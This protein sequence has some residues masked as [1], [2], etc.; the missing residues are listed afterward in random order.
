MQFPWQPTPRWL[1]V[2]AGFAL[3]VGLGVVVVGAEP[4]VEEHPVFDLLD[5]YRS[6]GL[7]LAGRAITHAGDGETLVLATVLLVAAMLWRKKKR[8]ALFVTV[9]MVGAWALTLGLKFAVGRPRPGLEH[10]IHASGYA[11][12]SGH[13]LGALA[14]AL[15]ASLAF[16]HVW[17]RAIRPLALLLIPL[18]VLVGLS[19]IYLRVHYPTDVAAGF[20]L[21]VAWVFSV[22]Y[23]I[24]GAGDRSGGGRSR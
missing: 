10:L 11:F 9:S 17:P 15:T 19:R 21:A 6:E 14:L 23:L 3:F 7:D 16:G 13:S 20:G 24:L 5:G 1:V 2:G 18:A 22:H 8:A 4:T 12:P